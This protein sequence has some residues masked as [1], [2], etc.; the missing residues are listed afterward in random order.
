MSSGGRSDSSNNHHRRGPHDDVPPHMLQQHHQQQQQPQ[1]HHQYRSQHQTH[2]KAPG[3]AYSE[4]QP[5]YGEDPQGARGHPRQ[6]A[7]GGGRGRVERGG[8]AGQ[9][10]PGGASGGGIQPV[11]PVSGQMRSGHIE[12]NNLYGGGGGEM[13]VNSMNAPNNS[14]MQCGCEN[15]DCPFCNLMLSVQMKDSGY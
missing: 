3:R 7:P 4:Q 6:Q 5:Y 12:V 10:M 14:T 2:P 13:V 11:A 1:Q 8:G 9:R 15:I